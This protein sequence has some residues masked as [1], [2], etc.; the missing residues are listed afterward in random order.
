MSFVKIY[1]CY[2]L[3]LPRSERSSAITAKESFSRFA[4]FLYLLKDPV[5]FGYSFHALVL[6]HA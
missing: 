3:S 1:T 5:L 4:I 2:S 6:I